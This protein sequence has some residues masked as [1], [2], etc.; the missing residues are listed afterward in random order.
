M[1]FLF[2]LDLDHDWFPIGNV[3]WNQI[4]II[5]NSVAC[6]CVCVCIGLCMYACVCVCFWV[7]VC[8]CVYIYV[9]MYV[10]V[11]VCVCVCARAGVS[12]FVRAQRFVFDAVLYTYNP[13]S[14]TSCCR[15]AQIMRLF[16]E[17]SWIRLSSNDSNF[18]FCACM[19]EREGEGGGARGGGGRYSLII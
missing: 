10:C 4:L 11:C 5:I 19:V 3:S 8:V 12:V 6:V 15:N 13:P 1:E 7:T 2:Q 17:K 14:N 9:Y 16:F 18:W